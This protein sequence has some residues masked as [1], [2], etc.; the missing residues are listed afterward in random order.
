M[1]IYYIY[2][3]NE[4][5]MVTEDKKI[6]QK[7]RDESRNFEIFMKKLITKT[8]HIKSSTVCFIYENPELNKI[9]FGIITLNCV[10]DLIYF[11]SFRFWLGPIVCLNTQNQR[12][13][14][15]KKAKYGMDFVTEFL[16]YIGSPFQVS[17]SQ[18]KSK[19]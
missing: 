11:F 6:Y 12:Q 5:K 19:R 2:T 13:F 17:R 15:P 14:S 8:K 9:R 18:V 1:V 4:R 7:K 16:L 10:I 3:N